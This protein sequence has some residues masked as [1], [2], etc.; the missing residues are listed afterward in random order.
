MPPAAALPRLPCA[1]PAFMMPPAAA[2]SCLP[3]AKPAVLPPAA[4]VSRL[5]CA[6][7]AVLLPAAAFLRVPGAKPPFLP[8]AAAFP[9]LPGAKPAFLPPASAFPC[10]PGAKP[11]FLP[12]AAGFPLH[13]SFL[14][15]IRT[16]PA[17]PLHPCFPSF[18]TSSLRRRFAS[19]SPPFPPR[20]CAAAPPRLSLLSSHALAKRSSYPLPPSLPTFR[21][22]WYRCLRRDE[23]VAA[24]SNA[25]RVWWASRLPCACLRG[26]RCGTAFVFAAFFRLPCAKPALLPTAVEFSLLPAFRSVWSRCL[27]RD[28]TAVFPWF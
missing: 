18:P 22:V 1:K 26:R 21:S 12:P 14:P 16:A 17:P 3:G 25:F 4:A 6:K 10:V 5:P 8:P 23:T 2:F 20:P 19:P 13:T 28:E 11:P 24:V 9:R 27:R 7:P 15:D